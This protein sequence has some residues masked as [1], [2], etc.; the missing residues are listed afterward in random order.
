VIVQRADWSNI[1][2]DNLPAIDPFEALSQFDVIASIE[3]KGFMR[4]ITPNF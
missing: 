3:A 2:F 1:V 4:A